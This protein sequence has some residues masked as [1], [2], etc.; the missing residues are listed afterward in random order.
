M[1][2]SCLIVIFWIV[3][4]ALAMFACGGFLVSLQ[5]GFYL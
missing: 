3:F 2:E 5:E 1:R 4:I